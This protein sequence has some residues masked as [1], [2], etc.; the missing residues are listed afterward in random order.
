MLFLDVKAM[1]D[2]L[3]LDD[4]PEINDALK[5]A[6]AGAT[7]RVESH[8]ST[9]FAAGTT[10][11]LF[12]LPVGSDAFDG[13]YT[14]RLKNGFVRS[15]PAVVISAGETLASLATIT[16]GFVADL[17]KGFVAVP[18]DY[19]G[20]Y[21]RVGYSY[22]FATP[23]ELP[24]WLQ[25]VLVSYSIKVLSMGTVNDKKDD[26]SKVFAMVDEHWSAILDPHLRQGGSLVRPI[27]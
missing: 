11:D 12:R 17:E 1:R 24:S 18:E 19:A 10:T 14:L 26:L 6:I 22:G 4:K 13:L 20:K 5:S 23:K 8:L 2:R 3:S 9:S 7:P 25:E 27:A 21:V 16:E 15:D